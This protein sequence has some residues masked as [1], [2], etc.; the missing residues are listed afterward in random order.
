MR[1]KI[2]AGN[3]KM[4]MH[5]EDGLKLA[6]EVF[7]MTQSEISNPYITVVVAPPFIHLDALSKRKPA[8]QKLQLA[9]QNCSDQTSGAFTG[10][11]SAGMLKSLGVAYV[12]LGHS[13][14]RAIYGETDAVVANKI[15]QALRQELKPILCVGEEETTREAGTQNEWVENQLKAA[16]AELSA[17]E[18][19]EVVIAYEPVWAIGTGKNAT[20]AQAQEMHA[21]IRSCL[22]KMH[23][24]KVAAQCSILY[25]GSCK[26]D[27]AAEIFAGVDVDG[28]LIGGASL[29]SRDFLQI[30]HAMQNQL[31]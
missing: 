21:F 8:A 24:K 6:S 17:D 25:G 15:K 31:R 23:G 16:V 3:W 27:N 26:P 14:R 11:I 5:Y 13:E 22:E 20:A 9:A 7:H 30:V 2:I 18:M 19:K 1:N 12:I 28:G 10:E 4:N 29:K